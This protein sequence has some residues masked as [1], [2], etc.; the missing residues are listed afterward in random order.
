M[1]GLCH[2]LHKA[3]AFFARTLTVSC[4]VSPLI[5]NA[6]SCFE[7]ETN[8][9][10]EF[11]SIFFSLGSQQ[12]SKEQLA[13]LLYALPQRLESSDTLPFQPGN[14]LQSLDSTAQSLA[15][16]DAHSEGVLTPPCVRESFASTT[17]HSE[18]PL[19]IVFPELLAE[20]VSKQPFEDVITREGTHFS[21]IWTTRLATHTKASD[22]SDWTYSL[23]ALQYERAPLSE[24]FSVGSLDN[25]QGLP[26]ANI[27]VFRTRMGSTE[28]IGTTAE[29][30]ARFLPRLSRF[31]RVM[32]VPR[33]IYFIGYSR[34][35]NVALDVLAKASK[36]P[37]RYPWASNVR[38]VVTLGG[39]NFGS[40]VADH[41]LTP[42]TPTNRVSV[43]LNNLA[44]SLEDVSPE[45]NAVDIAR[46]V[47]LNTVRWIQNGALLATSLARLPLS[48]GFRK[49]QPTLAIPTRENLLRLVKGIFLDTFQLD[50]PITDY[51]GNVRRFK[52]FVNQFNKAINN[53]RTES[54][55]EWWRTHTL[56]EGTH[57]LAI[58]ATM[59]DPWRQDKG[60][61]AL[62]QN[63]AAYDTSLFDF[64]FLRFS[65]YEALRTSGIAMNDGMVS[66][67]R[68]FFWPNTMAS[69]NP[70]NANMNVHNLGIFGVD[71]FGLS[72]ETA[73][74]QVG[75][76]KSPF[77]REL[78]LR[79]LIE[80]VNRFAR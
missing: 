42:G 4:A 37:E 14:P 50:K 30:T 24:L 52:I 78:V 69:L 11:R 13:S 75:N 57:L 77:P 71:H 80:Y 27:A 72:L 12:Y 21:K 3:C 31:F 29:T 39:V 55:L 51:F 40:I 63:P 45:D 74:P 33:D 18:P 9:A 6:S 20:I 1:D 8:A 62:T 38:G 79:T 35:A 49:E 60:T 68:A 58:A 61:W 36:H 34:G 5:A 41:A 23:A 64:S 26:Q 19:F 17:P 76:R 28:S 65:Y 48:E 25:S 2:R 70:Q 54:R 53:L 56:P 67:E 47:S 16:S 22:L 66:A 44:N 7:H 59:G 46:K 73:S 15:P 43:A 32:N 10:Q